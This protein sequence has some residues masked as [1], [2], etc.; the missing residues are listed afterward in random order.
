M[1]LGLLRSTKGARDTCGG[2]GG[3]GFAR[4]H[5][6]LRRCSARLCILVV[7]VV[8]LAVSLVVS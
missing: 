5:R 1:I 3:G 6:D 2:G 7:V 4:S 8:V